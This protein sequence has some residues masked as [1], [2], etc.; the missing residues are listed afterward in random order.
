MELSALYLPQFHAIPENDLWWGEGFTE[1]ANVKKAQPLFRGHRQPVIPGELGYYNLLDPTVRER[2]AELARLHGVTSFCYWHYWF[3]GRQLLERPFEEVLTTHSPSLPFFLGWANQSW[4]GIWH[5]APQR[6][7]MEQ[8]YPDGDDQRHFD[9]LL[10]AF[11]DDRYVH[12]GG[13]P[14]LMIFCPADLPN[15]RAFVD[16]WQTMART[17][18]LDGL[19]LVAWIEGRDWGVNYATHEADGFD[20]GLYVHFPF[21]R[22]WRT[23]VRDRLRARDERFGPV[24]YPYCDDLPLPRVPLAGVLHPSVQPNWDNTPRSERRG[25]VALNGSPERFCRHLTQALAREQLRDADHQLCVVK[26]WNEWAE[27]NY[28]EPDERFGR[29][30]LE[31]VRDARRANGIATP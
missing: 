15:P 30:W 9:H 20:A 29:G 21:A 16:R 6:I 4:S 14:V 11:R 18:G 13:R 3:G 10:R 1:W 17:A 25:A 26:S 12:L 8:T 7:L 5:G 19:Y 24:R 22:S 2:Q 31:A 27:G 28:L 23:K